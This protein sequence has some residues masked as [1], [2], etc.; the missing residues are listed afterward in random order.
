MVCSVFGLVGAKGV[1]SGSTD[2]PLGFGRLSLGQRPAG[3]SALVH[4]A[5][6]CVCICRVAFDWKIKPW[7]GAFL[8]NTLKPNQITAQIFNHQ[9]II[10]IS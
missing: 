8:L 1:P 2:S 9:Y 3:L 10:V 7:Q 6:P 5:G 4:I